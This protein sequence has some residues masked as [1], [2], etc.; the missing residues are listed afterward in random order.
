MGATGKRRSGADLRSAVQSRTEPQGWGVSRARRPSRRNI[1]CLYPSFFLVDSQQLAQ[2]D[3]KIEVDPLLWR[4][5]A[6]RSCSRV[7]AWCSNHPTT[8]VA[9]TRRSEWQNLHQVLCTG[10]DDSPPSACLG[11]CD[12]TESVLGWLWSRRI[13]TDCASPSR[14]I[15]IISSSASSSRS[16]TSDASLLATSRPPEP[17]SP[18][19]TSSAP[20]Y[21]RN[22]CQ[23]ALNQGRR[24]NMP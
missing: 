4:G 14:V 23:R 6:R 1:R 13:M 5:P 16:S 18:S 3:R 21:G 15:A 10:A 22:E 20:S 8:A 19:S 12:A 2:R 17:S 7:A 24:R 11:L 9:A